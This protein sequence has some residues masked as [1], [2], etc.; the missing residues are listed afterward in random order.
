MTGGR[1][2][3]HHLAL[4]LGHAATAQ[5]SPAAAAGALRGDIPVGGLWSACRRGTCPERGLG[6]V[7]A[8]GGAGGARR[9]GR[10]R[11]LWG[12]DPIHGRQ[13]VHPHGCAPASRYAI[14]A[15]GEPVHHQG[16]HAHGNARV[17]EVRARQRAGGRSVSP[18]CPPPRFMPMPR[19]AKERRQLHRVDLE[20]PDQQHGAQGR[21]TAPAPVRHRRRVDARHRRHGRQQE[22]GCVVDRLCLLPRCNAWLMSAGSEKHTKMCSGHLEQHRQAASRARS[23]PSRALASPAQ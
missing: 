12:A 14:L 22:E 11:R 2:R 7:P 19:H 5:P 9:P 10:A 15:R 6:W 17:V 4:R 18:V 21:P 16:Q 1:R 13:L 23:S 8:A 20:R 3:A